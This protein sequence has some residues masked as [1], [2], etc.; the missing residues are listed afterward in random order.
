ML[1]DPDLN[2]GNQDE[3]IPLISKCLPCKTLPKHLDCPQDARCLQHVA[4]CFEEFTLHST[5]LQVSCVAG[6]RRKHFLKVRAED[7]RCICF[8]TMTVRMW[9]TTN[10]EVTVP[11]G[12]GDRNNCAFYPKSTLYNR[13]V[14]ISNYAAPSL[15][16]GTSAPLPALE[17]QTSDGPRKFAAMEE[18][19]TDLTGYAPALSQA[20]SVTLPLITSTDGVSV[21]AVELTSGYDTVSA[22]SVED[23][24]NHTGRSNQHSDT[25]KTTPDSLAT[26]AN[27]ERET[28]SYYGVGMRPLKTIR[29]EQAR[30]QDSV[31]NVVGQ[32]SPEVSSVTEPPRVARRSPFLSM[33][34]PCRDANFSAAKN[35]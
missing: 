24:T 32:D 20:N 15:I 28:L 34:V 7:C 5:L 6:S 8:A 31:D 25:R 9:T 2:L 11:P 16:T 14:S 26:E 18:P 19:I 1:G 21:T 4:S 10:E 35:F 17:V 30:H 29:L 22:S 3:W 27:T 33:Q 13:L 23:K 12:E